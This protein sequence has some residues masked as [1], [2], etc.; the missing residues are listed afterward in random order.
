MSKA[1]IVHELGDVRL[2]ATQYTFARRSCAN[3]SLRH[4]ER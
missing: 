3:A 4:S 2:E 1:L